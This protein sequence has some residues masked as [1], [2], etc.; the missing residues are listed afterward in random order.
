MKDIGVLGDLPSSK[1]TVDVFLP[2]QLKKGG[3]ICGRLN[4]SCIINDNN[5][6]TPGKPTSNILF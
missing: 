2:V 3:F 1:S 5:I 4:F 6:E